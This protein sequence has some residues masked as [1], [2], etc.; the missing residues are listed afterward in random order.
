MKKAQSEMSKKIKSKKTIILL[1]S[2]FLLGII[3]LWM[4]WRFSSGPIKFNSRL[5]KQHIGRYRMVED[6]MERRILDGMSKNEVTA[7]LGEGQ[8]HKPMDGY[9]EKGYSIRYYIRDPEWYS[10]SWDNIFVVIYD[11]EDICTGCTTDPTCPY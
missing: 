1:I 6:L 11:L 3:F 10:N 7:L 9:A 8:V 2:L 4:N 5:W